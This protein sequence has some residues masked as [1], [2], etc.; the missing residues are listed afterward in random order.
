MMPSTAGTIAKANRPSAFRPTPMR[1]ARSSRAPKIFCS[2]PGD[3]MNG[4]T[5]TASVR[6]PGELIRQNCQ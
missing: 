5:M 1:T 3:T 2:R 4:G 6:T